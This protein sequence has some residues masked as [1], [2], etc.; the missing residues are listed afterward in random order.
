[1]ESLLVNVYTGIFNLK[2]F[3]ILALTHERLFLF[4]EKSL[5][6]FVNHFRACESALS[7]CGASF[8]EGGEPLGELGEHL[9]A[10][11]ACLSACGAALG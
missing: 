8:C 5:E 3:K 10:C 6:V 2:E 11:A 9:G 1:M 7:E 4:F